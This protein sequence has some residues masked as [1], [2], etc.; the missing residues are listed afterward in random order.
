MKNKSTAIWFVLAVLLF[1]FTW[2]WQKHWRPAT[3]TADHLL[4]GLRAADVTDIEVIPAGALAID[5]DNTNGAWQLEKPFVYPAQAAA[6][7]NLIAV[8]ENLTPATRL[9]AAEIGLHKDA[10]AEYGFNNPQFSVMVS[11]GTRQ[12]QLR[13]G[14]KTAPG[15]QV[16]VRVAGVDGAFVTDAGW[17]QFLPHNPTAWRDT[18]LVDTM[19]SC[20]WIVVTNG[21][22]VMELRRD[23]TNQFWH[24]TQPLSARADNERI[25]TALQELRSAQIARFVSDDPKAD[26]TTF[27]LQPASLDLWLGSGTNFTDALHLGKAVPD[28]SAL[29]FARRD[30]WNSVV[31]VTNDVFTPWRGTVNDFRDPRLLE[32]TSPVAEIDVRGASNFTLQQRGSNDWTLVGEKF[33]ADADNA[34]NFIRTLASL[35]VAEFVK[36]NNTA[37]DLQGYGLAS[38]AGTN[39]ITLLSTA[40]DTNSVIAQIIFGTIETNKVYVKRADENFVYALGAADLNRL[41]PFANGWFFRDR[42]IWDFSETNVVQVTLRQNGKTRTLLRNGTSLWSLATGS[43]G[44]INPPA[45]EETVHRLGELTALDWV[46]IIGTNST[47]REAGLNPNNLQIEIELKTG[48]KVAVDFGTELAKNNTALA[49]VTLDG[50]RRVFIFP[51]T[52]YQ[53]V[54]TYLT[55]PPDAP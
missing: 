16:F 21:T 41:Q 9:T 3:P 7:E 54:A 46:G 40:G 51:P 43:Q 34:L 52:V 18:S 23:T 27:G 33:P 2:L 49:S 20:D 25:I 28:N 39:R 1:A 24:M 38:P 44:I 15:D 26:L 50:I 22:R 12:W 8:L 14:N 10:D 30:G 4:P 55:I 53:F 17:L 36:D 31:A 32:L 48:E 37:T 45:V 19:S 29:V 42:H 47:A 13:I 11:T 6:I 35:R 5:A